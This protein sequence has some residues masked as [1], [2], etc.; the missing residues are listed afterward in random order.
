MTK[1]RAIE[2]ARHEVTPHYT[3]SDEHQAWMTYRQPPAYSR[4]ME[5]ERKIIYALCLLG[6]DEY[7]A[8]GYATRCYGLSFRDAVYAYDLIARAVELEQ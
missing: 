6:V 5:K 2:K 3:W 8:T 1:K 4:T 7:Y